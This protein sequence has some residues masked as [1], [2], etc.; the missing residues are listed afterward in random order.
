MGMVAVITMAIQHL[1]IFE[2]STSLTVSMSLHLMCSTQRQDG[3][4]KLKR[5]QVGTLQHRYSVGLESQNQ[6]NLSSWH[7]FGVLGQES[8]FK[9]TTTYNNTKESIGP[10]GV[11]NVQFAVSPRFGKD[12]WCRRTGGR[13][14]A[15]AGGEEVPWRSR[16]LTREATGL[17]TTTGLLVKQKCEMSSIFR[18]D[19]DVYSPFFGWNLE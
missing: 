1:N 5:G 2:R 6:S 11:P 13:A 10:L 8:K 4:G 3:H 14:T 17:L 18:I 19:A 16:W 12:W 9:N 7:V 15:N